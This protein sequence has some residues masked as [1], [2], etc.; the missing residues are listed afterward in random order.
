MGKILRTVGKEKLPH[1]HLQ[2]WLQG[3]KTTVV[4]L[5]ATVGVSV[6][7][8][9]WLARPDPAL[10]HENWPVVEAKVVDSRIMNNRIYPHGRG[11]T[12]IDYEAEYK[13]RYVVNCKTYEMWTSSGID[14]S[15][16]AAATSEAAHDRLFA[17]Y[18][19]RYNPEYPSQAEA[20]RR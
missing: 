1:Q 18:L 6:G 4:W 13:L 9:W 2:F 7:V 12:F 14:K 3:W 17:H 5:I 16:R 15:T 19:V 11:P 8:L 20:E 10:H